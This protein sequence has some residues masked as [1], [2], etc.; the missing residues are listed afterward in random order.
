MILEIKM[1]GAT[2]GSISPRRTIVYTRRDQS[3]SKLDHQSAVLPELLH[4]RILFSH[5]N[6]LI[7]WQMLF[8]DRN[9]IAR[10]KNENDNWRTWWNEEGRYIASTGNEMREGAGAGNIENEG[11]IT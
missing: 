1:K 4:R 10:L 3:P 9:E 7:Y 5:G 11:N 2:V 6:D 8:E